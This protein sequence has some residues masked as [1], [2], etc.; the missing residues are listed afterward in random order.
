MK[1]PN[2]NTER[3]I[4]TCFEHSLEG[5]RLNHHPQQTD[6]N[7]HQLQT[8]SAMDKKYVISPQIFSAAH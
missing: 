6:T 2:H 8:R 4:V 3:R 7:S 1:E 5:P